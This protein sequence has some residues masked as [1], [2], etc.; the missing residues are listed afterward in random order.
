MKK[1]ILTFSVFALICLLIFGNIKFYRKS[2]GLQNQVETLK[3][4]EKDR[5]QTEK[6]IEKRTEEIRLE[7]QQKRKISGY[8]NYKYPDRILK[9]FENREDTLYLLDLD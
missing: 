3:N 8:Q 2:E 6:D 7:L 5:I 1:N 9:R 4:E